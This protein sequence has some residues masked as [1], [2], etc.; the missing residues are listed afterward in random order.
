MDTVELTLLLVGK[1]YLTQA[2]GLGMLDR[3]L[4]VSVPGEVAVDGARDGGKR[5]NACVT[6][7]RE[8]PCE[9]VWSRLDGLEGGE[10]TG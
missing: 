2:W 3:E 8:K 6:I 9:A 4:R 1:F 7:Y 10:W 5:I